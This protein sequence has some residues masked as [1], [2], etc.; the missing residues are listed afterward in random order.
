MLKQKISR[1]NVT[2]CKPCLLLRNLPG[3]YPSI[4][5]VDVLEFMN[6]YCLLSLCLGA[7]IALNIVQQDLGWTVFCQ[8]LFI[9][10]IMPFKLIFVL[11]HD[12]YFTNSR[13]HPEVLRSS[14]GFHKDISWY[15]TPENILSA[16][17]TSFL[18]NLNP[19]QEIKFNQ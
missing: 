13:Y 9:Q 5:W 7:E 16:C 11:I 12:R 17:V 3:L 19:S 2:H 4:Y 10:E 1:N 18:I 15:S 14:Y 8:R 6:V